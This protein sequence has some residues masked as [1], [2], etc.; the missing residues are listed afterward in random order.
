M[1]LPQVK[2]LLKQYTEEDLRLLISEM[3]KSIPKKMREDKDI[4]EMVTDIH[5]YKRIGKVNRDQ[6]KK[7][8]ITELK[9]QIEQF[10]DF[11]YNQ[12]YFA[13][14]SFVHKKERPKWR[15]HVKNFIKELESIPPE[16]GKGKEATNLLKRLYEMLSYGCAYYIFNTDNPFRSVGIEQTALLDKVIVRL[17]GQGINDECIESAIKLVINGHVDRVTLPSDLIIVFINNLKTTDAKEMAIKQCKL[18]KK[19]LIQTQE[20]SRKKA[21]SSEKYWNTEKRN[22][23]TETIFRIHM[24]LC[25]HDEAIK[26]FHANYI[27]CDNEISLY[28]LLHLLEDYECI[29]Y[30]VREYKT[31]QG[32]GIEPRAGLQKEYNYVMENEKF[33]DYWM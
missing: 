6:N 7:S 5:A 32:K 15:F 18:I 28:V 29:N 13:P 31:A 22:N 21:S 12:Y 27:E 30:W 9:P 33:L 10:I 19:E 25:E 1:L 2:E 26:Y 20:N 14:N 8:D 16:G 3:Y 17:L 24:S 4:D 23:L 11:A